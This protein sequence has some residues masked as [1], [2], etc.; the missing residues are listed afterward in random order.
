MSVLLLS[1][2]GAVHAATAHVSVRI[3][4]LS[5]LILSAG[6]AKWHHISYNPPGVTTINGVAWS[7]TGLSNG[8]NC[9]SGLYTGLL[10]PIAQSTT[11]YS[12]VKNAGRGAV[13]IEET[14]SSANGWAL[15]I[16]I[17]D[18]VA[19]GDDLYNFDVNYPAV[20]AG[21]ESVPTASTWALALLGGML[22][23]AGVWV[24]RR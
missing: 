19:G 9:D 18:E 14:P 1:P 10:P 13:T 21:S 2:A 16:R 6:T 3:D 5:D 24:L 17:D 22:A 7:P 23:L 4:G 15:R 20:S 8:C 12:V 11:G